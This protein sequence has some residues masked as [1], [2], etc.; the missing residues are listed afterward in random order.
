[1]IA[2]EK[3]DVYQLSLDF[4]ELSLKHIGGLPTGYAELR[5]QWKRAAFSVPLNIAEGA[6]KSARYDKRRFYEIAKGSAM[7][8]A[9]I[10][11]ILQR[12][13]VLTAIEHQQF[14]KLLHRIISMLSKLCLRL[15]DPGT[16]DYGLRQRQR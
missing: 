13:Q 7:E 16:S 9:A 11:D 12:A 10:G 2:Y 3:L 14:K 6:G 15:S 8:S 5:S 1:M 4:V